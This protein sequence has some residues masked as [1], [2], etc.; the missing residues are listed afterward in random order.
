MLGKYPHGIMPFWV[1]KKTNKLSRKQK[2]IL[3]DKK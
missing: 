1:P 2:L 3:K